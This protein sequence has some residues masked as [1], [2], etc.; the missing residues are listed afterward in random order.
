MTMSA[1][2]Q[3]VAYCH[4][5]DCRRWTGGPVAA[6]AAFDR[7]ALSAAPTLPAPTVHNSGVERWNCPACGS[8]LAAQFDYLPT[9]VY[10]PL[11]VIDQID[12]LAPQIHCHADRAPHWL[13]LADDLP[14]EAGSA[15]ATLNDAA[16]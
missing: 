5:S 12:A 4:C 10:V 9:Q 14:R 16:E 8:P 15:R 7:S 13:H 1:S 6:F 11:G 2:P 3:T